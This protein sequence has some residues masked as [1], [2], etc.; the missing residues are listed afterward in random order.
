MRKI[1]TYIMLLVATV[2]MAQTTTSKFVMSPVTLQPGGKEIKTDVSLI[3][4]DY[5]FTGY[6]VDIIFPEG[7]D[8]NYYKQAPDVSMYKKGELYPY[9]EDEREG[10]KE[11]THSISYTYGVVGERTLRI[12]CSSTMNENFKRKS[13]ILFTMYIKADTWA[14]LGETSL[15]IANAKF[16][17][18]DPSTVTTT[19]YEVTQTEMPGITVGND[20]SANVAVSAANHWSTS[21]LPFAVTEMPNGLQA[22]SCDSKDDAAQVFNLKEVT[23]MEAYKPYILYSESGYEGTLKGYVDASKYP[24]GGRVVEGYLTGAILSQ[25]TND[26][27][28][29]QNLGGQVAFYKAD[30]TKEYTIPAGKCW[31]TPPSSALSSYAFKVL[32]PT[33]VEQVESAQQSAGSAVYAIDGKA[34]GTSASGKVYICNG[35]ALIK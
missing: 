33:G 3:D 22:Y 20:A 7:V 12:T 5:Y 2:A 27:Y 35:K 31:A 6:E 14:K 29:L 4:G 1:L 11:F 26:G 9:V 8:I 19:G 16:V 32:D 28:I 25:T 13:G 23:E 24:A 10:T 17:T 30:S 34:I 18:Y 21:I 15:G